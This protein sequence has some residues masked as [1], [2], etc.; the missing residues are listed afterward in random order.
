[1]TPSLFPGF[2]WP[3]PRAF[4]GAVSSARFE[5]GDVLYDEPLAYD[6]WSRAQPRLGHWLQVLDPPRSSRVA[7]EGARFETHWRS[8]VALS[9]KRGSEPPERLD[10]TQGR[11]FTCLWRGAPETLAGEGPEPPL[12]RLAR[13]LQSALQVDPEDEEAPVVEALRAALPGARGVFALG[14]DSASDAALGK[15]AR[16]RIRLASL[17]SLE[18]RDLAPAE[19]GVDGD[20]FHP[21][22]R[23]AAL[24]PEGVAAADMHAA[25]RRA[26][27]ASGA[28]GDDEAAEGPDRFSPARHGLLLDLD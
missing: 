12:P 23:V 8:S 1:M 6:D 13:E 10:T 28:G 18:E 4:A 16:L 21:A 3:V 17:A 19:C 26:L 7:G 11:L 5:E 20:D 25:L 2:A 14:Y 22:L 24:A 15:L 27:Y 9:W